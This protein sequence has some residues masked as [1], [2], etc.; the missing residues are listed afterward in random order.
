MLAKAAASSLIA[1]CAGLIVV[2]AAV[3]AIGVLATRSSA[4]LGNEIANDELTTST[5]TGQLARDMDTAYASGE[6]AFL[7]SS[8]AARSRLLGLLYT[9][10]LP[11]ANAQLSLLERLHAHDPPAEQAGIERF[12]RQWIVV[13]DLLSPVNV[14]A[15]PSATLASRL[16]AAYQPVGA[17]LD[18]L[19]RIEQD[20]GHREQVAASAGAARAIWQIIGAAVLGIVIGVFLL[21]SGVRRIRRNLEPGQDQAEFA[22]TLQIAGD[23]D[24]AHQLLQRHLE[25]TLT[26]TTVVVLNRNTARTGWRRSRRCPVVRRWRRRCAVQSPVPASPSAQA[27]STGR[28]GSG[29]PCSHVPCASR[30]PVRPRVFRSRSGGK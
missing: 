16:T 8:P 9:R 3:A 20:D 2:V 7:V 29:R 30:V 26:A 18:Q 4:T 13:R 28:T 1:L 11:A 25:R 12:A 10:L 15:H 14:A 5:A 22:D 24:E 23:E 21:M 27:G 6:T 19:F 17:H